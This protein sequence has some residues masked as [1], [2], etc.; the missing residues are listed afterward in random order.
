M[1]RRLP[2]LALLLIVA[3]ALSCAALAAGAD[4][5][6]A[7]G[8]CESGTT[9][10]G[11][12]TIPLDIVRHPA[13]VK[14]LVEACFDGEGPFPMTVDTGAAITLIRTELAEELGLEKVGKPFRV[15]GPG[16][17]T[18]GQVFKLPSWSIGGVV[19]KGG[20]IITL[21]G[22]E[23]AEDPSVGSLGADTLSRFGA[24]RIDF[25][26]ETLTLAGK[27]G[28]RAHGGKTAKARLGPLVKGKPTLTVPMNVDATSRG[29]AQTVE[30][31]VGSTQPQPW[32]I[33]TGSP[34][35]VVEPKIAKKSGLKPLGT[36]QQGATYCSKVT[37][38]YYEA[39]SL[40]LPTGKL[41]RQAIGA[42]QGLGNVGAK[43]LLGSYSLLQFGS[44]VF[45]WAGE[46]LILGAG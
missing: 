25:R 18:K 4:R 42:I 26:R 33:D 19:L 41:K 37:V 46:K 16:C 24:A 21:P 32:L 40:E 38:T 34:F 27:E 44:V 39:P 29:V 5:T 36:P 1:K 22:P 28:P 2:L 6:F 30:V 9:K 13:E 14:P 11:V 10:D 3:A 45:D 17:T 35:S 31:K 15:A 20:D 43:G 12:T 7:Q 8:G 23:V